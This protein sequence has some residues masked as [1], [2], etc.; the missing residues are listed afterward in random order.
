MWLINFHTAMVLK[1]EEFLQI[2]TNFIRNVNRKLLFW[3]LLKTVSLSCRRDI[4]KNIFVEF[5]HVT[6]RNFPDYLYQ[7]IR[8]LPKCRGQQ[9]HQ[10]EE[11]GEGE[12]L[13][14]LGATLPPALSWA[15]GLTEL[16]G[17]GH[18]ISSRKISWRIYSN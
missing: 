15:Q 8:P 7:R 18:G 9:G 5:P 16:P 17:H 4:F 12:E 13:G 2:I 6:I 1:L 14:S 11:Q 10:R 3:S